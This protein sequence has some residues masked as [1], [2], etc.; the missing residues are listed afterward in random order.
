M[1]AVT[2]AKNTITPTASQARTESDLGKKPLSRLFN[3]HTPKKPR[4]AV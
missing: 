4:S 2:V 3:I 1:L